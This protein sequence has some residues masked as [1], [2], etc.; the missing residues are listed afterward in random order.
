MTAPGVVVFDVNE[1]LSDMSALGA[2]FAEVGAPQH[3]AQVW[4]AALLRDAF[5]LTVTGG[6]E[7]F[8]TFAAA[9]LRTALTGLRLDRDPDA[10]V[11][12]ILSGFLALDVHPDVPDGVRALRAA[13]LRLVTLSNGSADIAERLLTRAGLRAEFEHVLSVQDAGVWKPAG[14][15]YAYA[16]DVC[17]TSAAEMVMVAV[18]PWDIH[19]AAR[20]GLRTA[21]LDRDGHPYPEYFAAPDHRV[22]ALPEL[23][24][25]LATG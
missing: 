21:W 3:T 13:G 16:A 24:G 25:R 6:T 7:R 22:P 4:F 9:G 5:A 10:A 15:A 14:G 20:A 2:R 1:T 23:A 12:H 17:G 19:G 11:E 8:A 18:H